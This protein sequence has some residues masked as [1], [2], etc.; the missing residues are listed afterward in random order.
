MNTLESQSPHE[1]SGGMNKER[2][3]D[4]TADQAI[5]H[6]MKECREKK[7]QEGGR[8]GKESERKSKES[9]KI[10]YKWNEVS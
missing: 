3:N 7:R 10:L 1:W 4:P 9:P 2:Y 6:V 5:A 8:S